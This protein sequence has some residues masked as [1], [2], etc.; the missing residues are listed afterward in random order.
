MPYEASHAS[1]Q[2]SPAQLDALLDRL[3]HGVV[4]VS[5]D[6]LTIEYANSAAALVL[7][8]HKARGRERLPDPWPDFSLREY[9]AALFT[10]IA[11][12]RREVS[13]A[14]R[15]FILTGIP[16]LDG[17]TA[18]VVLEDV[19]TVARNARAEREF[20]ANAAHELLTPL[21]GIV[22]AAFALDAGAK[23]VVEDRDRFISHIAREAGRLT[24][25][26][27]SLL[28]LARAQSGHEPP[29]LESVELRPLLVEAIAA[30]ELQHDAEVRLDC[31]PDLDA[32]VEPDLA[33]QAFAN[34]VANAGRHSGGAVVNVSGDELG[35][36]MTVVEVTDQGRG[37]AQ[38]DFARMGQRFYTGAGR[39]G[40]GYGL[41]VSIATQAIEL[42]GGTLTYDSEPGRGTRAR[43]RL[44]RGGLT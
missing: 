37:I 31:P 28:M 34:L 24:R 15:T 6:S 27:R 9:A 26:A 20:V 17:R 41:G 3:P 38:D 29:R 36:H 32:F 2:L 42:L 5:R 11:A 7:H 16:S 22:T 21:T 25:I 40:G 23:L 39:D 30:A 1:A 13:H 14:G 4:V 33:G 44:P 43:V 10:G 18:T 35:E 19:S 12:A 8:P